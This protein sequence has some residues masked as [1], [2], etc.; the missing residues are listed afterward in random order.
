MGVKYFVFF[1]PSFLPYYYYFLPML[2]FSCETKKDQMNMHADDSLKDGRTKGK[3]RTSI[4]LN[5]DRFWF[6]CHKA[7]FSE[8]K[9]EQA[10]VASLFFFR[11]VFFNVLSHPTILCASEKRMRNMTKLKQ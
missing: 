3:L 8:T 1:C 2:L 10:V 7:L 4:A 6:S 5:E 9:I 11:F